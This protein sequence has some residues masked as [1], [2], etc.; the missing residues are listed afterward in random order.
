[1]NIVRKRTPR[2]IL[3]YSMARGKSMGV[4]AGSYIDDLVALGKALS[5]CVLCVRKFD[6]AAAGYAQRS[7][8]PFARGRCDGCGQF[9]EQNSLLLKQGQY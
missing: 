6:A 3:R 9:S 7:N 5:L 1:M 2:E 4:T 8:L